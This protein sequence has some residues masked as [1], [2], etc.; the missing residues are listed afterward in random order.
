MK[1]LRKG[2]FDPPKTRI[3]PPVIYYLERNFRGE[4]YD[5]PLI[6]IET[7]GCSW[8]RYGG[9]C[10]MCNFGGQG[11]PVSEYSLIAQASF[12][13]KVVRNKPLIQIAPNGS[14]FDELEVPAR[15]RKKILSL[16][17]DS[18]FVESFETEARVEHVNEGKIKEA[19]DILGDIELDIGVGLESSNPII[20]ELII[21]K[22]LSQEDYLRFLK[23]S[24]NLD[25]LTSL[26][27][28]LKPIILTEREAIED[29]VNSI[30][31][32]IDHGATFVILMV[33]NMRRYTL[34][35]LL[36]KK[37]LYKLPMLWSVIEVLLRLEKM[38]LDRV[39]VAGFVSNETLLFP[40]RNCDKCTDEVMANLRMFQY[41]RDESFLK[42]AASI[43]CECREEWRRRMEEEGGDLVERILRYY[44]IIAKE[45]LGKEWWERNEKYVMKQVEGVIDEAKR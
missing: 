4:P 1:E 23:L 41:T 9:G 45:V 15:A 8:M 37:G 25:F 14:L 11:V 22:G 42:E 30:K 29:T 12:G 44:K 7:I 5:M 2:I 35:Y 10:T 33:S 3:W 43:D 26:H 32:A 24:K 19:K 38:Y 6:G 31:W 39:L 20:R 18:G 17:R 21:N 34:N 27:V 40:A 28:L 16:V 13:L 36:W